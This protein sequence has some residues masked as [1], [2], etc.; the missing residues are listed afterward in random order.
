VKN[1]GLLIAAAL[2]LAALYI[3]GDEDQPFTVTF[4]LDALPDLL[5]RRIE[6]LSDGML[7][8]ATRISKT[9][10]RYTPLTDKEFEG[11]VVNKLR[12]A[13]GLHETWSKS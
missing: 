5:R 13:F 2:V 12:D 8:T 7:I 4:T 11:I 6:L 1:S 10:E 3:L 9:T